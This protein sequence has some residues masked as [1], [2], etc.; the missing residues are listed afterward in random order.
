MAEAVILIS[1]PVETLP[2]GGFIRDARVLLYFSENFKARGTSTVI[3]IPVNSVVSAIRLAIKGGLE[4]GEA[5][6]LVARDLANNMRR[7]ALRHLS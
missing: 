2:A 4:I 6:E 1:T 3:Y 7:V 5:F